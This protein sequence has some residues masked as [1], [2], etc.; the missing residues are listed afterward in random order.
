MMTWVGRNPAW[1]PLCSSLASCLRSCARRWRWRQQRSRRLPP[2]PRQCWALPVAP[3]PPTRPAAPCCSWREY[4]TTRT[5]RWACWAPAEV[6]ATRRCLLY[7]WC[8]FWLRVECCR[9]AW[10]SRRTGLC[11]RTCRRSLVTWRPQAMAGT[12]RR[13]LGRRAGLLCRCFCS[14]CGPRE[15]C[16]R[17][18]RLQRSR[19]CA[20]PAPIASPPPSHLPTS[21]RTGE[22][23]PA[24][25]SRRRP[26]AGGWRAPACVAPRRRFCRCSSSS[27]RRAMSD[28]LCAPPSVSRCSCRACCHAHASAAR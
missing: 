14:A 17:R 26:S 12:W 20:R 7:R 24:P 22:A 1:R 6:S 15:F 10:H 13:C 27:S 3:P 23:P 9:P 8:S 11:W 25:R 16:Q 4:L 5:P 21:G 28:A 19:Y 2:R 18:I